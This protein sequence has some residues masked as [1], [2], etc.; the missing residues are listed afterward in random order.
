MNPRSYQFNNSSM[1]WELKA[2]EDSILKTASVTNKGSVGNFSMYFA[3]ECASC[4]GHSKSVRREFSEQA[5]AALVCWSE[6]QE[7]HVDQ[8]LC[9]DC[10]FNLRDVLIERAGEIDALPDITSRSV[11]LRSVSVVGA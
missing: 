5:I 2:E 1:E 10:Y 7:Q 4:S 8:P 6:I 3:H 9:D 11:R